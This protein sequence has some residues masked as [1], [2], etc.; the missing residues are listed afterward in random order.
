MTIEKALVYA[1]AMHQGQIRKGTK[2]P[3]I[4]HPYEVMEILKENNCTAE[5]II[6]GVLHD[7]KEDTN[8]QPEEIKNLFGENVLKLILAESEDKT[9]SW[10]ERKSSTIQRAREGSLEAK[11]ICCADKLSNIR[12]IERDYKICG[13]E[14]WKRFGAPDNKKEHLAWYYNG[15][16]NELIELA[17]SKMYEELCQ[18][19]E[20]FFEGLRLR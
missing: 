14:L 5:V 6:A 9:K 12:A 15:I 19:C 13:E 2:I 16:K 10:K 17:G 3:Y 11:Q 7:I 1:T 4:M 8:A 20:R 18:I